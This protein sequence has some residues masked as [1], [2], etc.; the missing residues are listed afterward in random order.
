MFSTEKEVNVTE[1]S[2]MGVNGGL[3]KQCNA[4][5]VSESEL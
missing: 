1:V 3:L 4:S 2:R 5:C